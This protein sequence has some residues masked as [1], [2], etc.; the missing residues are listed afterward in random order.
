[1]TIKPQS[2]FS[3]LISKSK[4]L[5]ER[6]KRLRLREKRLIQSAERR[7]VTISDFFGES[8]QSQAPMISEGSMGGNPLKILKEFTGKTPLKFSKGGEVGVEGFIPKGPIPDLPGLGGGGG[9]TDAITSKAKTKTFGNYM[10]DAF[11]IATFPLHKRRVDPTEKF[12]SEY[13][14]SNENLNSVPTELNTSG[15]RTFIQPI[16]ERQIQTVQSPVPVPTPSKP[17]IIKVSKSNLP[18]SVASLLK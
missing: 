4:R 6:Q 11:K 18:P 17:K 2:F 7:R 8:G 14:S 10:K 12:A 9:G 13:I 5:D 3:D 16:V 15:T 1:M